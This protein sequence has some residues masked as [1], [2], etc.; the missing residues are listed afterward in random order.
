MRVEVIEVAVA[1]GDG[2]D[3]PG[4]IKAH[5]EDPLTVPV[6]EIPGGGSFV[7]HHAREDQLRPVRAVRGGAE[8]QAVA[9]GGGRLQATGHV[10]GVEHGRTEDDLLAG[11]VGRDAHQRAIPLRVAAVRLLIAGDARPVRRPTGTPAAQEVVHDQRLSAARLAHGTDLRRE[12]DV[13]AP[14]DEDR[15]GRAGLRPG[16]PERGV[17]SRH[18][19]QDAGEDPESMTG[20]H[21]VSLLLASA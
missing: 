4:C 20:A 15:P 1:I 13:T 21:G 10:V 17:R 16:S 3:R 8:R 14:F 19:Q 5:R 6:V 2:P 9:F 12:P 11:T 7:A 18:E